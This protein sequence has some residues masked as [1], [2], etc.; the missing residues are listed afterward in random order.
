M[1]LTYFL[2]EGALVLSGAKDTFHLSIYPRSTSTMFV[3]MGILK[4]VNFF[5]V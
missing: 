4:Y 5:I 1:R 3:L 2:N